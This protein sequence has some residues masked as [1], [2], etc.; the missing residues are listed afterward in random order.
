[1]SRYLRIEDGVAVEEFNTEEDIAQLFHPSLVWVE[2][3]NAEF[4]IGSNY[5]NKTFSHKSSDDESLELERMWR[6][7]ELVRSD[8]EL[9]KAQDADPK[10]IGSVSDWRIYRKALRAWPESKDFP[11]TLF[12]PKAPDT[13]E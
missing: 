12:R 6:D 9:Y 13:K 7:A 11:K 4:G 3:N 10:S 5:V 8:V 1:M 2:C